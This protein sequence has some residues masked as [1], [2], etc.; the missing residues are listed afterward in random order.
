MADVL[1][2]TLNLCK[3]KFRNKD[4][5]LIHDEIPD[6]LKFLGNNL[7]ISQVFFNIL[8]NAFDA[9]E[10]QA[11]AQ[12]WIRIDV[13]VKMNSIEVRVSDSGLG[14]PKEYQDKIFQ[15]FF[16][17]KDTGKGSGLG[18]SLALGIMQK[19]HGTIFL[20]TSGHYT[21]FVIKLPIDREN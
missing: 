11:H 14:I 18:L 1:E 2:R 12:K 16:S 21:C 19:H 5:Q 7:E 9:V 4:V 8:N 10:N 15:P 6:N 20:D 17:T 3:E 13:A